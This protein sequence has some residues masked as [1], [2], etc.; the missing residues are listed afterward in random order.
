MIE[1]LIN[2]NKQKFNLITHLYSDVPSKVRLI[3]YD[4]Y[5]KGAIYMDRWKTIKG[6]ETL[7]TRLPTSPKRLKVKVMPLDNKGVQ[8]KGFST[9]VLEQYP[10]CFRNPNT[11]SFVKFAQSFAENLAHL[12]TGT[13]KSDNR[14]FRID[15]FDVIRDDETKRVLSTPAR[16]SNSTGRMEVSKKHFSKMTIPMRMAILLHE[17]SHFYVN[18]ETTNEVEADLNAL[19]IYLG[20]GYPYIEAHKSFIHTFKKNETMQNKER[21]EHI[22]TFVKSFE[23]NKYSLCNLSN[24]R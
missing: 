3:V 10:L 5:K 22:K 19:R 2:S 20:L 16:I 15:L 14:K 17:Y 11:K 18:K 9:Q 23:K 8:I 21:Y 13:Y 1:K 12:P 7:E 24:G 4:P 6:S